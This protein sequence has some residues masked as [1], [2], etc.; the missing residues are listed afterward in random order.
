MDTSS[1]L[2]FF[3]I[4]PT[5]ACTESHVLNII[6]NMTLGNAAAAPFAKARIIPSIAIAMEC[7]HKTLRWLNFL[8]EL[9]C[10]RVEKNKPKYCGVRISWTDFMLVSGALLSPVEWQMR[11]AEIMNLPA[12]INLTFRLQKCKYNAGTSFD[13][14]FAVSSTGS[15]WNSNCYLKFPFGFLNECKKMEK[16]TRG[17]KQADEEACVAQSLWRLCESV[18][19]KWQ[20]N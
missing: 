16:S 7:T 8:P 14:L 19:F 20:S 9:C 2:D 10:R 3:I 12:R 5:Y 18:A 1:L 15:S 6:S 4:M 17:R 13:Y 11:D